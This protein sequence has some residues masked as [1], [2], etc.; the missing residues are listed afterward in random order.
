LCKANRLIAE[1][2]QQTLLGSM[3]VFCLRSGRAVGIRRQSAG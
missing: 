2:I 3:D 1:R